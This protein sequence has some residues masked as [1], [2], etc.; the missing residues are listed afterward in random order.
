MLD[1]ALGWVGQIAAWVGRFFPRWQVIH[2]ANAVVKMIGW[3]VRWWKYPEPRI[4]AQRA[5]IVLWWPA[6]TD[7]YEWPVVRQANNLQAQTIVTTDGKTFI[8]AGMIVFE[9][10]DVLTL[11]SSVFD[12]DDSIRDLALAAIH[13]ACIQYDSE[14]L[15]TASRNGKLDTAMRQEARARLR[16][17]GVT[18]TA[19]RLTDLAPGRVLRLVNSVP[20][21]RLSM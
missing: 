12:P 18:V 16:P 7:I 8:V 11:I 15:L 19:V 6:V 2:P 17:F 20:T 13:D 14:G 3:S 1:S 4:V 21:E 9:V 10:E 5:G